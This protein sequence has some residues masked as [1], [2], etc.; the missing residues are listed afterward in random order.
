MSLLKK[1][2]IVLC[3]YKYKIFNP[4]CLIMQKYQLFTS[5]KNKRSPQYELLGAGVLNENQVEVE[6]IKKW[7]SFIFFMESTEDFELFFYSTY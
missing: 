2:F 4:Y 6:F 5:Q 7:F 3:I 1:R